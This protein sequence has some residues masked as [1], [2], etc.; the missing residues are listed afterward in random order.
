VTTSRGLLS[1]SL[2]V[3]VLALCQAGVSA[4]ASPEVKVAPRTRPPLSFGVSLLSS[5]ESAPTNIAGVPP[6]AGRMSVTFGY[7]RPT[8]RSTFEIGGSSVVPY[9]SGIRR[10][11]LS[12]AGGVQFSRLFG[13]R[14]R[15]EASQSISQ[16]PFDLSG[17][18][19]LSQSSAGSENITG[20]TTS[21][22]SLM[23]ERELRY[24]GAIT[25]SRT[26]SRRSSA[27]LSLAHSGSTRP[28]VPVASSQI[29]A[30][31]I[32]RRI[33]T[34]AVFHAGY[35][36][37]VASFDTADREAGSRHDIDLGFSFER[38]LPF[39]GRT[40]FSAGTG[41]T[42]LTDGATHRLRFL[43]S[44]TLSRDLGHAWTSRIAYS[45]P[46]Q[47]VA[48]FRHPFLSDALS[49]NI[50]GRV[51]SAWFLSL[52]SGFARG[53]V[54]LA[55]RGPGYDSYSGSVRVQ[56]Q[57]ARAWRLEAEAFAMH[58][59]FAEGELTDTALPPLL[60]RRGVRAGISWSSGSPR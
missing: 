56:R 24:D 52:G 26:L 33:S 9:S 51:G 60:Q 6:E 5:L 22:G 17:L 21:T 13:R 46:M 54:G 23:V 14:T 35:G 11:L 20:Q 25:L 49:L 42:V 38:P 40:M 34:S 48:G 10:D 58:F 8:R 12:F 43:A 50:D 28:G 15:L 32:Q 29:V 1:A 27:A 37:G 18:S 53:S 45:R 19:G 16:R 59:A 44:G 39:S 30:A 31:R 55:A 41:S 36:F 2:L 47:Y 57:I 3:A 7:N 4:Q